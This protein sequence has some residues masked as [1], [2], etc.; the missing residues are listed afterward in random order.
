MKHIGII[1]SFGSGNLGDEA[2][3]LSIQR[4]LESKDPRWKYFTHIFQWS[5]P[6]QPCGHKVH[7]IYALTEKEMEW[8]NEHFKAI[9]IVGG[10]I[11][12]WNWGFTKLNG[13]DKL[14]E[15]FKVPIYTLSISA[16]KGKYDTI[17]TRNVKALMKVSKV[18]TVRDEF[19]QKNI[20]DL[21]G[22]KPDITPDVVSILSEKYDI[23]DEGKVFALKDIL[24]IN[25]SNSFTDE[26]KLFWRNVFKELNSE[27]SC[28]PF[29]PNNNDVLMATGTSRCPYFNF[30][31][32]EEMIAIMKKKKFVIAGRLHAAVFAA[33]AKIP[34]IA[35][36]YHPKVKAFCD[37][38]GYPHYFPKDNDLPA[39]VT[40]YG[41]DLS[42]LNSSDMANAIK[43]VMANPVIPPDYET[44]EKFLNHIYDRIEGNTV[45]TKNVICMYC[46]FNLTMNVD[47]PPAFM[48]CPE[49]K[50]VNHNN[51]V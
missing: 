30:Y 13:I 49:C 1:G 46:G 12:G 26:T 42:K 33:N 36:N 25:A 11:V 9:I 41:F 7:P 4:F 48:E 51:D 18:F 27:I 2:A 3:W 43:E 29:I 32:P 21:T 8:I 14:L 31:Q 6:Y 10:G 19:S 16:E 22:V 39:D 47:N 35:I 34:F 20:E 45:I 17:S 37:S 5:N 38:I 24:M 28:V 44:A 50:N 15:A 40:N 23:L